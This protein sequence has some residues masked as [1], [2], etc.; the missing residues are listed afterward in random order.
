MVWLES[1]KCILKCW[2]LWA[3][4]TD[5]RTLDVLNKRVST[6]FLYRFSFENIKRV[7]YWRSAAFNQMI[8]SRIRSF[9]L[10]G[11]SRLQQPAADQRTHLL[12]L[13]EETE[14]RT[15]SI[16][17]SWFNSCIMLR[18]E[19]TEQQMICLSSWKDEMRLSEESMFP[20]VKTN[21]V[22]EAIG[23]GV[24]LLTCDI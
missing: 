21:C 12:M 9:S 10:R 5:E 11:Y 15:W 19:K 14:W 7:I 20:Q 18:C 2:S 23:P 1:L 17:W 16:T 6:L 22:L 3:A 4:V 13:P 8:N 24:V